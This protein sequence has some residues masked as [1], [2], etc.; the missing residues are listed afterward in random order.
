MK[1]SSFP[2]TSAILLA[3]QACAASDAPACADKGVTGLVQEMF[4]SDK[5]MLQT[6]PTPQDGNA[7]RAFSDFELR[8]AVTQGYDTG[9]KRRACEASIGKGAKPW[10]VPYTVQ[11]TD[12]DPGRFV[13]RADFRSIPQAHAM[14]LR[15]LIVQA[16]N[17]P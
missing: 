13:V 9:L 16:I 2:L 10:R 4:W 8:D 7:W 3:A 5:L 15:E 17:K 6:V 12:A 1:L 11:A 14:M